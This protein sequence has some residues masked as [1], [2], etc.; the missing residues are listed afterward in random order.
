MNGTHVEKPL[1][2]ADEVEHLID[3]VKA[4][5]VPF[6]RVADEAVPS[7]AAGELLPNSQGLVQNA[8]VNARRPEN[9]VQE[10]ALSLPKGEGRGEQGLLG[11]I[12]DVLNYSVN[13]WDQG[14]MDKLYA[15]TNPY[16]DVGV[17]FTRRLLPV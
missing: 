12:Q 11:A 5:V 9:L 8:L 16:R 3:A 14:F 6:I 2:R 17:L 1:N 7:R 15:S 4:P 13:T 10:L